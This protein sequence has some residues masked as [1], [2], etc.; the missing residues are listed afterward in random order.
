MLRATILRVDTECNFQV[1]GNV[2]G[3]V[4]PCVWD[5][6]LHLSLAKI[7]KHVLTYSPFAPATPGGPG[8]PGKPLKMIYTYIYHFN[9]TT[10]TTSFM[11]TK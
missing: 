8:R 3:D 7:V 11:Q 10:T 6:S 2:A 4:A 5:F 9:L 1:V